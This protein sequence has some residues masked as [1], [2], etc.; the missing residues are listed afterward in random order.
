MYGITI[1][2]AVLM[3][4]GALLMAFCSLTICRYLVYFS[5]SILFLIGIMGFFL[6]ILFSVLA[7]IVNFGC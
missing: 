4:I 7:P 3:L 5:C 6:T 1:G 2:F